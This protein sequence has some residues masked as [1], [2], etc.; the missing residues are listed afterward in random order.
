MTTYFLFGTYT[1]SALK[2][3]SAKR[4]KQAEAL[5]KKN[6]G[7]IKSIYALLGMADLVLIVDLPSN[8]AAVKVSVGLSKLTGLAFSTAPAMPVSKFDKLMK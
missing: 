6:K 1:T 5:V 3:M 4:T 7:K 2:G 8:D